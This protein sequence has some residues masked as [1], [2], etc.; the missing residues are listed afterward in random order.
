MH[1]NSNIHYKQAYFKSTLFQISEVYTWDQDFIWVGSRLAAVLQ[2][3]E[4]LRVI[5]DANLDSPTLSQKISRNVHYQ[6]K[7]WGDGKGIA[8][9][10]GD[11][12]QISK[13]LPTAGIKEVVLWPNLNTVV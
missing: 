4:L 1:T 9:G 2:G 3:F 5:E 10:R 8:W 7:E 12:G 11:K 6:N 13:D